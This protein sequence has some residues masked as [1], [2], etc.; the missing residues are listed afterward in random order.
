[1][2]SIDLYYINPKQHDKNLKLINV[3]NKYSVN[4]CSYNRFIHKNNDF[5][6]QRK[7]R[8]Y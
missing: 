4:E 8:L 3:D 7:L 1:M 5:Q 6:V 2:I